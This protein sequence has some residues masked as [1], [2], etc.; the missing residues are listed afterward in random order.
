[1][2]ALS[3][4][5]ILES[6]DLDNLEYKIERWFEGHP[7]QRAQWDTII[8]QARDRKGLLSK[9]AFDEYYSS[10]EC[11][12]QFVDFM[13]D[14]VFQGIDGQGSNNDYHSMN[15]CRSVNDYQD[16]FNQIIKFV[17]TCVH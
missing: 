9:E 2:I 12:K 17:S 13:T 11:V 15:D 3:N 8:N 16:I 4:F 1:M 5:I 6:L 7:D 10:F 14:N